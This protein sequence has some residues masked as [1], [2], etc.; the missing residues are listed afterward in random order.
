M[1]LVKTFTLRFNPEHMQ[2][3][4]TVLGE[5]VREHLVVSMKTE[6]F[7]FR[8]EPLWSVMVTYRDQH[9]P[10]NLVSGV[11]EDLS[12]STS[13]KEGR[14]MLPKPKIDEHQRAV[15]EKLRLWR[16]EIARAK[17][18]PPGNLF[19]NRQLHE[20][21]ELNPHSIKQ[22]TKVHGVGT[23]KATTYGR[24]ILAF[25]SVLGQHSDPM[26]STTETERSAAGERQSIA[27]VS[28]KNTQTRRKSLQTSDGPVQ[29]SRSTKDDDHG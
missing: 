24:E 13:K 19:T 7:Y 26:A 9:T 20:I 14:Q 5:F 17:G 22:L 27:Q 1:T 23:Y 4:D 21:V 10:S 16:N 8:E 25:L 11:A 12:R 3:D 15:Y 18:H 6:F 28:E 2:F 29:T